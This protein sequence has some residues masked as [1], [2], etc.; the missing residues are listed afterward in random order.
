M[1]S[2]LESAMRPLEYSTTLY[3][4]KKAIQKDRTVWQAWFYHYLDKVA[5][6]NLRESDHLLIVADS[7][8]GENKNRQV[9][10]ALRCFLG[11][12]I[13]PNL[14]NITPSF[15]ERGHTKFEPDAK[16]GLIRRC[17]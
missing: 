12:Q 1:F 7:C 4:G 6:P 14:K 16:Y 2:Y 3:T 5:C 8:G 15:M 10:A 11:D 17:E 9:T 13:W